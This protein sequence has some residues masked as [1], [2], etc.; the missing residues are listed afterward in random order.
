MKIGINL[1]QIWSGKMGGMEQFLRNLIEYISS[2]TNYEIYLFL[3]KYSYNDFHINNQQV[4]KININ[5]DK[6]QKNIDAEFH[7]W[8]NDLNINLWFCPLF[9]L[10]PKDLKIPSVVMIPDIQH[11]FFPQFFQNGDLH[12]RKNSIEHA[13]ASADIILTIS[14]FSRTTIIGRYKIPEDKVIT[15]HGDAPTEFISDNNQITKYNIRQKYQLPESYGLYPANTWPHKNH[16]NL[17][18][19]LVILRDKYNVEMQLIFTGY[20]QAHI[21]NYKMIQRFITK[22][23]LNNQVKFLGYVLQE[24]MPYLYLNAEFLVYPSLFEGFGIPLVEAMKTNI[25]IICSNAGSIP[26]V[27]EDSALIFNPYAPEDIAIQMLEVLKPETRKSL[28]EKG[29][30]QAEKF[31]WKKSAKETLELFH[32]LVDNG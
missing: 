31:S 32:R 14:N 29:K 30:I 2:L 16:I 15:I 1:F 12:W 6:N 23:K 7:K 4:K 24:D 8:I 28:V 11:E 10:V 26:E 19:A 25:P 17:L 5:L 20:K 3:N 13:A 21:K 18:K 22:E 27:V 9:T